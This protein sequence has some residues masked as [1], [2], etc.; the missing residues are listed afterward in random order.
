[1]PNVGR[2]CLVWMP[3]AVASCGVD[4]SVDG[5]YDSRLGYATQQSTSTVPD[6]PT[7]PTSS[8]SPPPDPPLTPC[9]YRSYDDVMEIVERLAEEVPDK[10]QLEP[11]GTSQDGRQL[12]AVKVD[13]PSANVGVQKRV[14][15]TAATHGNEAITTEVVLRILEGLRQPGGISEELA[16][17]LVT[18]DLY[19]VPVV[20]PDG[21]VFN[22]RLAHGLDPNKNFPG[23][24][25]HFSRSALPS[26]QHLVQYFDGRQFCGVIDLHSH[27]RVILLPWGYSVE[28]AADWDRLYSVAQSVAAV[29]GYDIYQISHWADEPFSA[30]GS[31]ADCWHS[32][33]GALAIGVELGTEHRPFYDVDVSELE[34]QTLEMILAY[35]QEI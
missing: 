35:L 1:M 30:P 20:N 16:N 32:R 11:Y 13:N 21:F 25:T 28:R 10:I 33:N 12:F 8:P 31:S 14:M 6:S 22:R 2:F 34:K 4:R 5:S 23:P 9:D 3:I 19:F 18:V 29:D 7:E 26:V 17:V 24:G 15:I 27:S